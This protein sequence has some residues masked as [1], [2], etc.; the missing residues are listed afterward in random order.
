MRHDSRHETRR[1][2]TL[3]SVKRDARATGRDYIKT[4][5]PTLR[6]EPNSGVC[7]QLSFRRVGF[8]FGPLAFSV[9]VRTALRATTVRRPG[10]G[11]CPSHLRTPCELILGP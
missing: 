1:V 5:K 7:V 3:D 10:G 9:S 2:S 8:R 6:P 4:L 11:R